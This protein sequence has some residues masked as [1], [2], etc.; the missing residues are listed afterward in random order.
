[1]T[2]LK[3]LYIV[4]ICLG[5][6]IVIGAIILIVFLTIHHK[7]VN[8]GSSKGTN[9]SKH[10]N[11]GSSKGTNKSKHVNGGSSGTNLTCKNYK[12]DGK[13]FSRVE[14]SD[15]T[16]CLSSGCTDP[17]CCIQTQPLP[18]SDD[19]TLGLWHESIP[20]AAWSHKD[21]STF[22]GSA[23]GIG[24]KAYA[25]S[26]VNYVKNLI[27]I[28][29]KRGIKP[30]E[31]YFAIGDPGTDNTILYAK[32]NP[33]KIVNPSNRPLINEFLIEPL[34][35]AGVT[36][37]G[38]VL[39]DYDDWL[40]ESTGYPKNYITNST[41]I[42]GAKVT[43][44]PVEIEKLFKLIAE[45]NDELAQS[46][47]VTKK[48]YIQYLGFDNEGF[49]KIYTPQGLNSKGLCPDGSQKVIVPD[50]IINKLWDYYFNMGKSWDTPS[51]NWGITGGTPPMV[52][53]CK[54]RK[55]NAT[56]ING[57][58]RNFAFIEYYNIPADESALQTFDHPGY[59]PEG[60]PWTGNIEQAYN[61]GPLTSNIDYGSYNSYYGLN[62]PQRRQ[63][64][65]SGL[66]RY[67][68][69]MPISEIKHLFTKFYSQLSN[70]PSLKEIITGKSTDEDYV[71]P[72]TKYRDAVTSDYLEYLYK[73][74]NQKKSQLDTVGNW[75]GVASQYNK[76][77]KNDPYIDVSDNTRYM[78]SIENFSSSFGTIKS[79]GMSHLTKDKLGNNSLIDPTYIDVSLPTSSIALKFQGNG[80]PFGL[81][82]KIGKGG[83]YN[84]MHLQIASGTFE[85]LG[86]WELEEIMDFMIVAHNKT[87]DTKG[88]KVVKNFMIYEFNFCPVKHCDPDYA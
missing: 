37:F 59:I 19:V 16:Q 13:D 25:T 21:P 65:M 55:N 23:D 68:G 46:K 4:L 69:S 5:S 57:S 27:K 45:L 29:A 56:Y 75:V 88:K 60:N 43:N 61:G 71:Y 41:V 7:H 74:F 70:K 81:I 62:T 85:S 79:P 28:A 53:S 15:N 40:W 2:V 30:G 12:C 86:G 33:G 17:Y 32:P 76:P 58:S 8:G 38:L 31:F 35:L 84:L 63:T 80:A 11:G 6:L 39:G 14:G 52:G 18:K 49:G 78:L 47:T 26:Y 72:L 73:V 51:H 82:G 22:L 66:K 77:S 64:I 50:N 36:K 3:P 54:S 20:G 44:A 10:V 67:Y 42:N 1:M 24:F 34:A 83:K 9:K 87:L 48:L